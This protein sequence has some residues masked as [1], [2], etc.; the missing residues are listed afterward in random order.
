MWCKCLI[1]I[2]G[3]CGRGTYNLRATLQNFQVW[4]TTF[5]TSVHLLKS[6][7]YF[8]VLL[9]NVASARNPCTI[10]LNF[11]GPT[12]KLDTILGYAKSHIKRYLVEVVV[13]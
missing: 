11:G 13:N 9:Y 3:G 10:H 4:N 7:F 2:F 6:L 5:L 1:V 12:D 8:A